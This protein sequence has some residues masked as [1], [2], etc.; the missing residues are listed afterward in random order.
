MKAF[1]L[2]NKFV[3]TNNDFNFGCTNDYKHKVITKIETK[4]S[5]NK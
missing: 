1:Y 5:Q 2:S 3:C 4:K